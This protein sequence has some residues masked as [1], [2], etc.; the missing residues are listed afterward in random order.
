MH[1]FGRWGASALVTSG[2]ALGAGSTA[3]AND[4]RGGPGGPIGTAPS[5]TMPADFSGG[6]G[7]GTFITALGGATP[8]NSLLRFVNESKAAGNQSPSRSMTRRPERQLGTWTSASIPSG[9]AA[10]VSMETP[11]VVANATPALSATQQGSLLNASATA[12]FRG[13][14]QVLA[15]TGGAIVNRPVPV[16]IAIRN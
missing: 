15:L 12:T 11:T 1:K 14:Y 10:Q 13:D 8:T 7:I 3:I 16:R 9:A 6:F 4:G 5:S 2:L